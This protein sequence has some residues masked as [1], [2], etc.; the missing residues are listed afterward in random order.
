MGMVLPYKLGQVSVIALRLLKVYQPCRDDGIRNEFGLMRFYENQRT[1]GRKT[2]VT[3]RIKASLRNKLQRCGR[4]QILSGINNLLSSNMISTA[5]L[6]V[7]R[8][9]L[10]VGISEGRAGTTHG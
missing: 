4:E 8:C 6:E 3:Q 1:G 9:R 2:L 10:E 7:G 5:R